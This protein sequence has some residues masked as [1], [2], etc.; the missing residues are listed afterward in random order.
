MEKGCGE[1]K[2]GY[3]VVCRFM[4]LIKSNN[5]SGTNQRG[6]KGPNVTFKIKPD[7]KQKIVALSWVYKRSNTF[8]A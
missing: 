8:S 5:F 4:C 6:T 2:A 1:I 3:E 7:N